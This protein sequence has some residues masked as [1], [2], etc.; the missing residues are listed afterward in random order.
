MCRSR[1]AIAHALQSFRNVVSHRMWFFVFEPHVK[2][3]SVRR[4][5]VTDSPS[6]SAA[7]VP[8]ASRAER[9]IT[10]PT[11]ARSTVLSAPLPHRVRTSFNGR[12]QP[13]RVEAWTNFRRNVF[14]RVHSWLRLGVEL[15]CAGFWVALI[16]TQTQLLAVD[17]CHNRSRCLWPGTRMESR[18]CPPKLNVKR[19]RI[20]VCQKLGRAHRPV[21]NRLHP[22]VEIRTCALHAAPAIYAACPVSARAGL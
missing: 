6:A 3:H 19:Y 8:P 22:V 12:L 2:K 9:L 13:H 18:D 17:T 5:A 4:A 21:H 14:A 11:C 7:M 15:G 10:P 16:V 20:S 1:T